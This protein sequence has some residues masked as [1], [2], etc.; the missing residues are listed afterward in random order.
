MVR[1]QVDSEETTD[2]R[3]KPWGSQGTMK[4]RGSHGRPGRTIQ[5]SGRKS[6]PAWYQVMPCRARI[7]RGRISVKFAQNER[8]CS[9]RWWFKI[10]KEINNQTF[11]EYQSFLKN[12]LR[13]Q[14]IIRHQDWTLP[15]STP[16]Y[17]MDPESCEEA[18]K[19]QGTWHYL[20][21]LFGEK[22]WHKGGNVLARRLGAQDIETKARMERNK[23]SEGCTLRGCSLCFYLPSAL[24]PC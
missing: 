10:L 6:R 23:A 19:A 4:Q 7:P 3:L 17:G 5:R 9:S 22:S 16:I 14:R 1:Q 13:N 11:L 12:L 21:R 20:G 8:W 24:Q 18:E 2:L 15:Q